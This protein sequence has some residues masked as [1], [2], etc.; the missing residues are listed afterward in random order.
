MNTNS[1]TNFPEKKKITNKDVAKFAEVSVATVSYVING[2]T[3]Q[4]ISESTRKKVL[5]AANY[6]NYVPNTFAAG[7]RAAS[8]AQTLAVRLPENASVI[9]EM[10]AMFFFRDFSKV[11]ES[12]GFNL[13]YS[14]KKGPARLTTNACICIGM[15]K[16]EFHALCDENFIPVIALDSIIDDP[17]FYQ[18]NID[19]IKMRDSVLSEIGPFTYIAPQTENEEL[20]RYIISVMP[21]TVFVSSVSD[22]IKAVNGSARYAVSDNALIELTRDLEL[23]NVFLYE[24]YSKKLPLLII[25]TVK[26]AISRESVSNESHFITA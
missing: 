7:L 10:G 2:R 1:H 3:D 23:K 12:N 13:I 17:V 26:K 5:Q 24:S 18:I 19:L 16:T 8:P 11:C 22:L 14:A 15:S 9:S 6:L 4:R 25:D 20:R 21:D